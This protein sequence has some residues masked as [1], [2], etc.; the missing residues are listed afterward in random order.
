MK[1]TAIATNVPLSQIINE[2]EYDVG[3]PFFLRAEGEVSRQ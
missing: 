3:L 1:L 2:K